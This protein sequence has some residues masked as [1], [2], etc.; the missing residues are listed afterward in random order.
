MR[1]ISVKILY[2]TWGEVT[3]DYCVDVLKKMGH[4]VVVLNTTF[5]SYDEDEAFLTKVSKAVED[6]SIDVIFSFNYFPDLS[7]I[8]NDKDVL[9]ISWVYDCPHLTLQSNTLSNKNNRVFIFDK[10]LTDSLNI[11]GFEAVKYMPL[12][13]RYIERTRKTYESNISF[14]GSMYDGKQDYYGQI[15]SFPPRIKGY[16]DGIIVAEQRLYGADLISNLLTP[17]LYNEVAKYLN[18]ELGP[19][20]RKCGQEIFANML[21]RR[22]TMLDRKQALSLLDNAGMTVDLYSGAKPMDVNVNYKGYADY[23]IKMPKVFSSSKIN[24]NMTLRSITTGIPLRIMDILGA[25]GFCLTNYQADFE[26]YFVNGED[27]VWFYNMEELVELAKYY[28]ENDEE[29][30]RIAA[31][32]Q[33]KAKELFSCEKL[34]GKIL[35]SI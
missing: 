24:L 22:V 2:Y 5:S 28:L 20:Y 33:K 1:D 35:S 4:H 15:D 26:E 14:L 9:Y 34:L 6:N 8:A 27:M 17:D 19:N 11:Q 13:S 12:P 3:K 31:N 10:S 32:G 21:R 30:E 25:G 18:A 23:N 29:R 7:R 16:F